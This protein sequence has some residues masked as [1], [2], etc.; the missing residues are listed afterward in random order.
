MNEGSLRCD[1]NLSVRKKDDAS[2]GVRTE[3]KNLN[4]FSYIVKA[5]EYEFRRQVA[6]LAAGEI[7]RQQTRRFDVATGKTE[8]MR[9]KENADDYRYFPEPDLPPIHIDEQRIE[10][11]RAELPRLP[12]ERK[13]EYR[14]RYGL[15][16]Y[17]A[18]V[19][20]ADPMMA[21][22]FECGA[23][24]TKYPKLLA[25]MMLSELM[26]LSVSDRFSCP[27][28]P[29]H[30][31]ELAELLGN[32]TIN[33]STGKN[34]IAQMWEHDRSPMD[35]VREQNLMQINDADLL[36]EQV[37]QAITE[38]PRA[39]ADYRN[40]KKAAAKVIV[41]RVMAQTRGR[42]NP[43]LLGQLVEKCLNES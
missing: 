12:H 18:E 24:K 35:V 10:V 23:E 40:G 27:I 21:E 42:A 13:K 6:L 36:W 3:I 26:R 25:N 29:S 17:D 38:N 39:L 2:L 15:S 30:M 19:L 32:E 5:I 11:L 37:K 9:I 33:S 41:G 34:L 16:A 8:L 7:V 20:C 14:E 4:S 1:V 43:V 22:Y 28:A 31:A